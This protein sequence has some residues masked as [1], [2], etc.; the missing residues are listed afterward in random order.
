MPGKGNRYS[1]IP[2]DGIHLGFV[3]QLPLFGIAMVVGFEYAGL[4]QQLQLR[5]Q[6]PVFLRLECTDLIFPI[7][8]QTG[9]NRLDTTGRQASADLLPQQR[10][11]LIAYDPVQDTACLLG[12]HQVIVDGTGV[13]NRLRH[14]PL[15][16]FI[17]GNTPGLFLRQF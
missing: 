14:H 12:I 5:F 3:F 16:N 1:H 15:G 2:D 11:Q 6:R 10:R 13:G 9:G 8:N 7:H 4:I 17:K